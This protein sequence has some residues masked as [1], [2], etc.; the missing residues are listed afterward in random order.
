[1]LAT[2]YDEKLLPEAP[3]VADATD[4]LNARPSFALLLY[5]VIDPR[6]VAMLS[7]QSVA[8]CAPR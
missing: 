5:P 6:L 7:S 4:G 3:Y 2:L 8:R 1:M